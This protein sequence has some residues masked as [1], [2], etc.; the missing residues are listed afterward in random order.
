MNN[1]L[2][3]SEVTGQDNRTSGNFSTLVFPK[4]T[5][6]LKWEIEDGDDFTFD[7]MQ[8]VCAGIDAIAP[9][10]CHDFNSLY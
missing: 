3:A 5:E 8:D 2:I 9:F 6:S 1:H 10:Q 4:D 7:V